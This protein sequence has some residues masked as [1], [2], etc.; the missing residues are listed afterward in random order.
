MSQPFASAPD[1][2]PE[3]NKQQHGQ[4]EELNFDPPE[5]VYDKNVVLE[6][7]PSGPI[8]VEVKRELDPAARR[9]IDQAQQQEPDV[10]KEFQKQQSPQKC[11]DEHAQRIID[12]FN[13]VREHSK[14]RSR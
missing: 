9:A 8:P 6:P 10:T 12:R 1:V 13:H 3:F 4:P 7:T 2:T 5:K 14:G 11:E